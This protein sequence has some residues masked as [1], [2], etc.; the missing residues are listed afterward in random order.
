MRRL[1]IDFFPKRFGANI[2]YSRDWS[3]LVLPNIENKDDTDYFIIYVLIERKP[4]LLG[5]IYSCSVWCRNVHIL[6]SKISF[7]VYAYDFKLMANI[8]SSE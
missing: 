5:L 2:I 6:K 4:C 7:C 3:I 1:S 8:F